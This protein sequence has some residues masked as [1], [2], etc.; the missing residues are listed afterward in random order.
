MLA[1][2]S[3]RFAAALAAAVALACSGAST[4]SSS[5]PDPLS[6]RTATLGGPDLWVQ[7]VTAPA[8]A[9]PNSAVQVTVTV[10]NQGDSGAEAPVW[11]LRSTDALIALSDV[12]IGSSSSI[13]YLL[14]GA[15]NTA[16]VTA[17]IPALA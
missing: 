10:C 11:I 1:I 17:N 5:D 12:Q 8:S 4:S 15:C 14:P 9:L 7:S 3:P 16:V 2:P 13:G 6:T